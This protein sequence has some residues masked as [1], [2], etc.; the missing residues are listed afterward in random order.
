MADDTAAAAFT[1]AGWLDDPDLTWTVADRGMTFCAADHPAGACGTLP[2]GPVLAVGPP[3]PG[4]GHLCGLVPL[5]ALVGPL[6]ERSA[7]DILDRHASIARR[8]ERVLT[9]DGEEFV[10][11][12]EVAALGTTRRISRESHTT[13]LWID[14]A[15]RF[16]A[17]ALPAVAAEQGVGGEPVFDA[18]AFDTWDRLSVR[19]LYRAVLLARTHGTPFAVRGRLRHGLTAFLAGLS[20]LPPVRICGAPDACAPDEAATVDLGPAGLAGLR[21]RASLRHIGDALALQNFERAD[22]LV[23]SRLDTAADP[24]ERADLIRLEAISQAQTGRVPEA[25]TSLRSALVAARRP[26]LRAHVN[27][28]LGLLL[29]KRSDDGTPGSVYYRRGLEIAETG[30]ASEA[31]TVEK[32]W[33]YNGLALVATMEA[34]R[35]GA[36]EQEREDALRRA[37]QLEF[38]A[39]RLVRDLAGDSAFYLRYNLSH[40]L[41]FL[42]QIAGRPEK[43][44]QTLRSV[45]AAMLE[46]GK[47]DFLLLH[48][49]A[50]GIV[51]LRRGANDEALASFEAAVETATDLGDPFYLERTLGAA[52]YAA[53]RAGDCEAAARAYLRGARTAR[54]LA[55]TGAYP[56]HLAGLLWARSLAGRPWDAYE[57]AAARQWYPLAAGVQAEGGSQEAVREALT[58]AGAE[59]VPPSAKLPA[60]LPEVDLE[61]APGRDLNRFLAGLPSRE[62]PA[63][64]VGG[65]GPARQAV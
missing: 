26:E 60:Y 29:T 17:E 2:P 21:G 31:M 7:S 23:R 36:G 40:N 6:L 5:L 14:R 56:L 16:L 12:S 30:P 41:A 61:G 28:L 27:Y 50:I 48:R 53:L 63:A 18:A 38:D 25:V 4:F 34:R 49:Y 59:V 62:S 1:H 35:K 45:S 42:L 11:V 32:A 15:A 57:A 54:R 3:A 10:P 44:E 65:P 20:D 8:L 64:V 47:A 19:I 9:G 43:A 24:D 22:L 58:L 13:A 55:D 33:L 52:G 46:T 37:F 39:F 51:Q